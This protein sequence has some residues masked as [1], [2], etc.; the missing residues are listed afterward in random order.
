MPRPSI[1]LSMESGG[2]VHHMR[3]LELRKHT[4][5]LVFVADVHFFELETVGLRNRREVLQI[6][7]IDELVDHANGVRRVVDDVPD[8]GRPD[9]S[10]SAGDDDAVCRFL[11]HT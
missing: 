9:E 10:G 5:E 2:E 8:H 6:A 1:E 7:S 4:V 11:Q 3:R